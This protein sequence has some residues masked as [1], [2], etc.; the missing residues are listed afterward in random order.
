MP[1]KNWKRV[2]GEKYRPVVTVL[3][4]KNCIPTVVE[5]GGL[6]YQIQHPQQFKKGYRPPRYIHALKKRVDIVTGKQIGR[7]HV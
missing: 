2:V 6:S 5:I 7:A 1:G 4:T 3:E